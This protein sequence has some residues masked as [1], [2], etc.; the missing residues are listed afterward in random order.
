ME[1]AGR[2]MELQ[3]Q[4]H[5]LAEQILERIFNPEDDFD[6]NSQDSQF[7]LDS[8]TNESLLIEYYFLKSI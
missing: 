5:K 7:E 8:H 1:L 4:Q 6:R 2:E 3:E